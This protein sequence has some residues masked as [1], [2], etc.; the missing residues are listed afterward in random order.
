MAKFTPTLL[1]TTL[2]NS[3]ATQINNNLDRISEALENT[4]SRDG[5]S[6]NHMNADLDMNHS[7]ILNAGSIF[8]DGLYYKG[9]PVILGDLSTIPDWV[10]TTFPGDPTGTA[11]IS[12]LLL[13]EVSRHSRI[14]LAAG[15]YYVNQSISIPE[16]CTIQF[17]P[18]AMILV[19]EDVSITW[20]GGIVAS[21]YQQIF[22]GDLVQSS[23]TTNSL[24][25]YVLALRGDPKIAYSTPFWFGAVAD[26]STN[27]YNACV[28]SAY[29]GPVSYY[30][31]V[32]VDAG[33]R[34]L[35]TTSI[36][37]RR[38]GTK[39]KGDGYKSW[40]RL[41]S[42]TPSGVGQFFGCT[43]L[44]PTVSGGEPAAY[45]SDV[46]FEGLHID[47]NNGVND[48]GI[49]G[50][51]AKNIAVKNCF[52]S[53]VGR[54]AVTAQ[55]HV[56]DWEVSGN[57]VFSAS[58]E[59]GSTHSVFAFEGENS[60][61]NYANGVAGYDWDGRDNTGH[62]VTNNHIDISG[63][64]GLTLSNSRRVTVDG[65]TINTLGAAGR[66]V[67]V[68]RVSKNN[69]IRS[70]KVKTS[71]RGFLIVTSATVV[72][73]R[74][75]DCWI[76]D[77]SGDNMFYSEGPGTVWI[78]CG[79]TQ[80]DDRVAWSVRGADC[81][82]INCRADFTAITSAT[83]ATALFSTA[84]NFVMEG[85]YVNSAQ[86]LRG[87]GGSTASN[88]SILNNTFTG[89]VTDGVKIGGNRAR[90]MGNTI[91]GDGAGRVRVDS[92][93]ANVV[94]CNNILTGASPEITWTSTSDLWSSGAK[95]NNLRD[96]ATYQCIRLGGRIDICYAGSP[97]SVISATVGSTCRDVTNG[98][99]YTKASGSDS[100]GWVV[101]GTQT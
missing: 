59:A 26:N 83:A 7:S 89:G 91:G 72:S 1:S 66:P 97:A 35:C 13:E 69:T 50:N 20:N 19:G 98:K 39:I 62:F 4:L 53:N 70:V 43:G 14:R 101:T 9:Q 67:I 29:F 28:C 61:F 41:K 44:L 33:R 16:S 31:A 77:C 84:A 56:H 45:V 74:F 15:R 30:P 99:H 36:P 22:S 51:F 38:S 54:K 49:G 78:N 71:T 65:L 40:L 87:F 60:S 11:D 37:I 55:Y 68:A 58:T 90:V 100:S 8:T 5:T 6:P 85:C 23:Y 25:P 80:S 64:S 94:V 75:E 88:V 47:T 63:Y 24:T 73:T 48:N 27:D 2:S 42:F 18:G 3:A 12:Q 93:A 86:A 21:P 79:G 17:D 82:I 92:G 95:Y 52:F 81:K 57:R 32:D 46:V 76:D 10:V 96:F 34:Y